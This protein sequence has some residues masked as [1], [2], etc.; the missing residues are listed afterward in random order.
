MPS[1]V[2]I[3]QFTH[4]P[5]DP[6]SKRHALQASGTFNPRAPH[7]RHALFQDSDFFDPEDLLQLKYE[8]L[9]ALE[10]DGSS[11]AQAA[12]QFGLSRPTIYQAQ[13]QFTKAGLEGLLPRKRGPKQAH[14]LTPEVR[15]YLHELAGSEPELQ[16][17]ELVRRLRQRFRVKLHPRTIEKALKSKAKKGAPPPTP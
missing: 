1:N 14:K 13:D 12:S 16:A 2:G 7:V 8:T 6:T 17:P 3:N 5:D 9:R 11:I 4:M 10:E 15:H